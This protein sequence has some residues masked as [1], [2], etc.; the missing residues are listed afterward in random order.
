MTK[1][2]TLFEKESHWVSF[3]IKRSEGVFLKVMSAIE[4]LENL[5]ANSR[6]A[7]TK[8]EIDLQKGCQDSNQVISF[9]GRN[10]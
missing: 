9:S 5:T 8:V 7:L 1:M 6:L 4:E 10:Q 3:Y 2:D